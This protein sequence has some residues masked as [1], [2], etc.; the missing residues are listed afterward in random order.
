MMLFGLIAGNIGGKGGNGSG[1]VI[2]DHCNK[3][4]DIY[5]DVSSPEL[6]AANRHRPV[7][8]TYRFR[9]FRGAPRDWVLR[10]RFKKFKIGSIVNATHCSGGYLQ[11]K[12]K[13]STSH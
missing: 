3:T 10:L 2:K 1:D 11:V 9:S 13:I 7:L 6:T 5:E 4:V 12:N 8:C